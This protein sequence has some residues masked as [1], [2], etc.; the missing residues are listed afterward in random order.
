MSKRLRIW[1]LNLCSRK[2]T[3]VFDCICLTIH[4]WSSKGK[5]F[6]CLGAQVHFFWVFVVGTYSLGFPG[7]SMVENPPVSA[8]DSSSV[9]GSGRSPGESNSIPLQYSCL[10]N[11]MDRR[12][13]TGYGPLCYKRVRHGLATKT[14]MTDFRFLSSMGWPSPAPYL[15]CCNLEN[16]YLL[17]RELGDLAGDFWKCTNNKTPLR[18]SA[19]IHDIVQFVI[20]PTIVS[21]NFKT[22]FLWRLLSDQNTQ[23]KCFSFSQEW[24]C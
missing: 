20:L 23:V 17:R 9:P 12:S 18:L 24:S 11:P 21:L 3:M 5:E 8:G 10:E 6:F 2:E 14:T 13:L 4:W 22:C 16:L 19:E 7:D 1:P 15:A